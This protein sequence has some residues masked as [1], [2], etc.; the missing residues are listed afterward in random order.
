MT[1]RDCHYY[2]GKIEILTKTF[3]SCALSKAVVN[4][5]KCPLYNVDLSNAKICYN[6]KSYLGGFDW[7]LS[8]AKHYH[9]LTEALHEG[10]EDFYRKD[11]KN[12]ARN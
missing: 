8:C 2:Q 6:C 3:H 5:E 7:G 1:C 11:N 10:C 9:V 12:E 4:G